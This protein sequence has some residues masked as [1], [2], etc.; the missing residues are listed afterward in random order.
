MITQ[1][2]SL[3][4]GELEIRGMRCQGRH[5]AYPGE[6]DQPRLFLVDLEVRT[7]LSPAATTDLL[8]QA[9]DIAALAESVRQVVAGP[10]CALL[11]RV[12]L[13]VVRTVLRRFPSIEQA[14]VRIR[15]PEPPGLEAT[16]ESAA[17]TLRRPA[18][19]D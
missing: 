12:A 14:R 19:A 1:P 11:E 10:P 2:D 3:L 16:E 4:D 9:L 18:R 7:D 15:K 5:G 13:D 17:L 6:Q 8:D